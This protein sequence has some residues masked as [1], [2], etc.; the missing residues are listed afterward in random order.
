MTDLLFEFFKEEDVEFKGS[1][2][3]SKFS[4]IKIGGDA[5]V[6]APHSVE[7]L[8]KLLDFLYR[9]QIKYKIVGRMSNV[10]PPDDPYD[11]VIV[12]TSRLRSLEFYGNIATAESGAMLSGLLWKARERGLG[13]LEALYG[14]PASLGGMIYSNAGAY[15]SEISDFLVSVTAYDV[16]RSEIITIPAKELC[17][18]YRHS[19][20]KENELAILSAKLMLKKRERDLIKRDLEYYIAKRKASQ[21]YNE[22]SLGSVFKRSA[23]EPISYL[24]DKAGLKGFSVGGAMIS[25]KHA[26]FIVNK[27]GA[28]ARDVISLINVIKDNIYEK[29]GVMPEEE[30]EYLL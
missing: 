27:G 11:G 20:F 24:I 10:L 23:G 15:G 19:S 28:S 5:A 3:L 14:I 18:S 12:I 17:F 6:A 7:K 4:S 16:R 21:P 8:V 2:R 25:E 1:I 26:G 13:G 22:P 9:N 29:Y 30:I